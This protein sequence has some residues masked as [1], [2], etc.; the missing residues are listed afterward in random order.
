MRIWQTIRATTFP[1]HGHQRSYAALVLSGA[2][3]E[4]GDQG[5]FF[6]EAGDVLLHD[7]FEAHLNRFSLT[8]AR[9]LNLH[10][11]SANS[12][13]PGVARVDDLDLLVRTAEHDQVEAVEL[14]LRMIHPRKPARGDWP[15]ELRR[16]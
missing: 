8:G 2:Y 7:S 3:E 10:L 1:R 9:V 13:H 15:D 14:L 16:R 12:F 4:A 6:V 5:R 11:S